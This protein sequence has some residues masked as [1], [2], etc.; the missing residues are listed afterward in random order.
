MNNVVNLNASVAIGTVATEC[1]E[2]LVAAVYAGDLLPTLET[3]SINSDE[4]VNI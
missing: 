1:E 3:N 2:P 4:S